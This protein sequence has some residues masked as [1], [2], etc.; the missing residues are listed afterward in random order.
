MSRPLLYGFSQHN[1]PST[2]SPAGLCFVFL[3]SFSFIN[4]YEGNQ[5]KTASYCFWTKGSLLLPFGGRT[6]LPTRRFVKLPLEIWKT[7]SSYVEIPSQTELTNQKRTTFPMPGF[8]ESNAPA[9]VFVEEHGFW[10]TGCLFRSIYI[11]LI[12]FVPQRQCN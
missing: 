7:C 5:I 9:T 2:F 1:Y 8:H 4:S 10:W 6:C 12:S 11:L 3:L